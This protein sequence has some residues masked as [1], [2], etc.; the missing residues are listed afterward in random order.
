MATVHMYL[1]M[2]QVKIALEEVV[3][4]PRSLDLGQELAIQVV[5]FA[6]N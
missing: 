3:C 4:D 1:A 2:L 5:S 6:F